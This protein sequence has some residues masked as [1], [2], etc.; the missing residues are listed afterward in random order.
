MEK[1]VDFSKLVHA[2]DNDVQQ[3]VKL[4]E[5]REVPPEFN[6]ILQEVLMRG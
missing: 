1:Y 6:A 5:V 4:D 2:E 3:I